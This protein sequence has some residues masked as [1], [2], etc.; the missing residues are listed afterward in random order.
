MCCKEAT[1]F[2]G[3]MII[4]WLYEVYIL[5]QIFSSS[6][7]GI[8][9]HLWADLRCACRWSGSELGSFLIRSFSSLVRGCLQSDRGCWP[10]YLPVRSWQLPL[11]TYSCISSRDHIWFKIEIFRLIKWNYMQARSYYRGVF[12]KW[13]NVGRGPNLILSKQ[14]L[15]PWQLFFQFNPIF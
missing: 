14:L 11:S 9:L 8:S 13:L 10:C 7:T 15:P 4:Q 3:H 6:C 12:R 2:S 5:H 1:T